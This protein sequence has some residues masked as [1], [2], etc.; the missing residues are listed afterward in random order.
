MRPDFVLPKSRIWIEFDGI[1]HKEYKEGFHQSYESYIATKENDEIKN[2]Y[3]K[4]NNWKL[5]RIKQCDFKN[6]EEIINNL[7]NT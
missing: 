7:L 4:E 2:K 3:A 6:I 5:I 1:Q